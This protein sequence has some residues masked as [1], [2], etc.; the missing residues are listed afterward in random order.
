MIVDG[1]IYS[2]YDHLGNI[3]GTIQ[4]TNDDLTNFCGKVV[5]NEDDVIRQNGYVAHV[6]I[7]FL[8]ESK[9]LD[10]NLYVISPMI[11]TNCFQVIYRY[12]ISEENDF[13]EEKI[14][15][16]DSTVYLEAGQFLAIGFGLS[17]APPKHISGGKHYTLRLDQVDD[18][19][20]NNTSIKFDQ[21]NSQVAISFHLVPTQGNFI[22][23]P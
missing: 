14:V 17:S 5:F 16:P 4:T 23:N 22:S 10:I 2:I 21:G 9:P 6:S 13:D 19:Y 12:R 8:Q 15:L 1:I 11:D 20:G 7:A 18:A 3:Y